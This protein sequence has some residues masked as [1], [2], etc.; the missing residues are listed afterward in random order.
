MT[1]ITDWQQ[2]ELYTSD[3][4]LF[5]FFGLLLHEFSLTSRNFH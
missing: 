1:S 5:G 4:R 3:I 2:R